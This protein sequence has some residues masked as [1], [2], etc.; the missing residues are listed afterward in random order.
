MLLKNKTAVI[1]AATGAIGSAVARRM[2]SDGARLHLS[3]RSEAPLAAL[4]DELGASHQVVDATDAAAIDEH[5]ARV[6]RDAGGIDITFD[7]IGP[8]A[9]DVGYGL[10]C[11]DLTGEDFLRTIALIAGSQ[12]LVARSVARH[13]SARRSGAIIT[14]SASLSGQFVPF[15]AGITAACSA[16]EGMTR[17]L[18]A[19]LGP[20]GVRVNCLRAGGLPETRTIQETLAAISRTTGAPLDDARGSTNLRRRALTVQE[21]AAMVSFVGSDLASGVTGQILNVCGGTVVSR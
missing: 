17:S 19:E 10:R 6:A 11:V 3:G 20:H 15:M 8:R 13:M 21:I 1:F 4:A 18:A 7:A 14:L 9:A 12:F 5:L 16:V 2:A